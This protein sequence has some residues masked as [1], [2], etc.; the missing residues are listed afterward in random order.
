[1]AEYILPGAGVQVKSE[2]DQPVQT[3]PLLRYYSPRLFGAPPQL[4]NQCD[5]RILSSDGVNPGPVGDFYLTRILQ[6]A[7]IANFVVGRARFIGGTGSALNIIREALF[8][9]KALSKYNIYGTDGTPAGDSASISSDLLSQAT[10]EAYQK[11]YG[12]PPTPTKDSS[13]ISLGSIISSATDVLG[14]VT[15]VVDSIGEKGLANAIG[16]AASAVGKGISDFVEETAETVTN[17]MINQA[18]EYGQAIKEGWNKGW[19]TSGSSG[20][21]DGI[22]EADFGSSAG[23][24]DSIDSLVAG[25]AG[26]LSFIKTSL[27]VQQPFYTFEDDWMS[28]INNVK[29]MINTAVIMLGLQQS[30]V[31]IGDYYY[32]VGMHVN[33]KEQ[34]DV[35]ANYRYITPTEGLGSVTA[36]NTDNGD[37]SQYVSFMIDPSG[38]S[39]SINN[40]IGQSQI[41]SSV[42]NSGSSVGSEIAFITNSTAGAT[43]DKMISI[44]KDSKDAADKILKE[45]GNGDNGRFTAAIAS[46]M[47]RSF[48]GDHTIYPEV[49]QGHS[50]TSSMAV[51][52][53]LTSDAGDPY[54]YL[55]NILVPLFFILGMALP[56]LS[57][58]NASAYTYPPVIQCN[59][60][61]MWGTR[62]GMIES[63]TINKNPNGKDVSINGYPLQVDVQI[64]IKDL[65]HVLM[66]SPMNKISVFLNNHTMFDYIAQMAG[67]DKYRVNGSMRTV[68]RLALAASAVNNTFNNISNAL[69][70]DWHSITNRMY[71]WDRQ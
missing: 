60:P 36:K 19:D 44:A 6:D 28:Y 24:L 27:S 69:L 48:T 21:D 63:L 25:G 9:G 40:T 23:I 20:S 62:L 39:E 53:H 26:L 17:E 37:T 41:Y 31:R 38:A 32:P 8:Y 16:D 29:M 57:S 3:A 56:Q 15:D 51:T 54:S 5:M 66:T 47:A 4:T 67:V 35:W 58:N 12:E 65:Q 68:A 13:S 43:T 10:E 2:T 18:T 34:N 55:T 50:A 64:N 42:I 49:F 70:T 30:C 46:S 45:L 22:T 61:G 1:M 7:N 59:I 14:N 71:G 11:A 52:V 33:V